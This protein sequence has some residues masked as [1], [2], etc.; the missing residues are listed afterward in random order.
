MPQA[1]TVPGALIQVRRR[2]I[3]QMEAGSFHSGGGSNPHEPMG[4]GLEGWGSE[5]HPLRKRGTAPSTR[6]LL[7][8]FLL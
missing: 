4:E 6:I 5:A 3:S 7:N 1:L 8:K 2:C